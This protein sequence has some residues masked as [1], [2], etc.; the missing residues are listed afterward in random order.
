MAM[1]TPSALSRRRIET[2]REKSS[3]STPSV[4]S[5]S[6]RD[7]GSPVSS[8]TECTSAGRSPW[9]N[10]TG[11]RLIAICSGFG[12]DAA[13]RQASRMIHSPIGDDQ[14]AFLGER[15]EGAGRDH[16]ALRMLP[17]HQRLEADDLAVD[18]RLRLV[19]QGQFAALDRRSQFLLQHAPLAQPL[20]HVGF[21]E[22]ERA[23]ALRL[24][25][26][27]RGVGVADQR[28]GVGAVD[29][30]DR[31]ADAQADAHRMA[32]DRDLVVDRR[33][34]PIRQGFGRGGLLAVGGDDDEFVA[35]EPGQEGAAD[36]GLQARRQLRAAARRR[37]RG[38]RR[39]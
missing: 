3:I 1:R 23:A 39:R 5:S 26:I 28:G 36:G 22:A 16:A 27:E 18:A 31:D 13:S 32:V 17:A 6:S 8:S 35:A 25:A 37:R 12:Q 4:I 19:V 9:R 15:D 2:A 24:G 29:R 33:E 10:C 34:Q 20:V 11:D 38:R 7:G 14:P 21:E 30:E